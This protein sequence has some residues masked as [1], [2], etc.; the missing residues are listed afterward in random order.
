MINSTRSRTLQNVVCSEEELTTFYSRFG[1]S[2]RSAYANASSAGLY[3]TNIRSKIGQI[4]YE[5]LDNII[6]QAAALNLPQDILHQIVLISPGAF[7]NDFRVSI[8][9]RYIYEILRN[10]LSDRKLEAAARL[11]VMFIRTPFTRAG[12]RY[13]L[14]DGYH[15]VLR[16]GG[17]WQIVRMVA[18]RPGPKY[19]HWR[20]P[21]STTDVEYFRVGYEGHPITISMHPLSQDAIYQALPMRDYLPLSQL[22]LADGYYRPSSG[23]EET[24][25]SFIY[26]ASN[27]TATIFQVT[28][29]K[30]HSVKQGGIEWL[31]GLGVETFRFVAVMPPQTPLDLPFPNRWRNSVV[32]SIPDKYI[33]VLDSLSPT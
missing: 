2:A 31:R 24:L 9:T 28:V 7:R 18:N 25:D 1:P 23:S 20:E 19:T 26:E 10:T 4:T 6:R 13:M 3:E 21:G 22:T 33:L 15:D 12:A 29:S 5:T 17:E 14:D 32:P 27:K 30:K 8:P 16:K 11:Y